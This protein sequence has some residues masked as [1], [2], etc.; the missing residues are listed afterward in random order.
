MYKNKQAEN[1]TV[2]ILKKNIIVRNKEIHFDHL[3]YLAF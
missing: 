3:L 1:E 2:I